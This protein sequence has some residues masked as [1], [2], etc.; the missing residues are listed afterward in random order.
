[1][2]HQALTLY[3]FPISHYCEKIRWALDYKQLDYQKVNW[4][5]GL[6][7]HSAKKIAATSNVPI[8]RHGDTLI[9]G[10]AQIIDYLD[11]TF[12][13]PSLGF[14]DSRL[15][16]EAKTWENF[17]DE[18]IGPHTRRIIYHDLLNYPDLVIPLFAHQGPWYSKLYFKLSYPKLAQIM[19]KA[20]K[21][22]EKQVEAS[23]LAL[24]AALDKINHA[25]NDKQDPEGGPVY[26]TGD[27]FSRAELSISALLAPLFQADKYGLNWPASWPTELHSLLASY[28]PQIIHARRWYEMHR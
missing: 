10:S 18:H 9:Q 1:M 17:A 22:N 2:K 11:A 27:R 23:K 28:Q 12:P 16:E 6:H 13:G 15:N 19:R 24:Q 5:P 8:L 4:L 14:E 26:L 21:I 25:L 7:L 3:Q 20:M